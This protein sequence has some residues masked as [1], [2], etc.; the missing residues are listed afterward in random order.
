LHWAS[1]SGFGDYVKI[2]KY[3]NITGH[4]LVNAN[5]RFLKETLGLFREDL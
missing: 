3:E 1:E 5:K 4:D 2:L